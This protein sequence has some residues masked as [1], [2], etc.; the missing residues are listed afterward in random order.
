M[1]I[2]DFWPVKHKEIKDVFLN[3]CTVVGLQAGGKTE[4]VNSIIWEINHQNKKYVA[5]NIMTRDFGE[6]FK[7]HEDRYSDIF[8]LIKKSG[9][10][11]LFIDDAL[12]SLHSNLRKRQTDKDWATIRHYFRAILSGADPQHPPLFYSGERGLTIN[13]FFVTQ[14]Y[15]LLAPF[16]REAPRFIAKAVDLN[17]RNDPSNFFMAFLGADAVRWLKFNL[18]E[19]ELKM[20][21]EALGKFIFKVVGHKTLLTSFSR[22][23]RVSYYELQKEF[24]INYEK[25]DREKE[26]EL[27]DPMEIYKPHFPNSTIVSFHPFQT[28]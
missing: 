2:V 20:N 4:L 28:F 3:S 17:P 6:I 1:D 22:R 13:A 19:I 16:Q 27:A 26:R 18:S 21:V 10:V 24:D 8:A 11:N 7:I 12:T 9:I 23:P 25:E 15:Q 5:L 14:R